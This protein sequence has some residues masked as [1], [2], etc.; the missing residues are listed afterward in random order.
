VVRALEVNQWRCASFENRCRTEAFCIRLA[1]RFTHLET[2]FYNTNISFSATA[3]KIPRIR[4]ARANTRPRLQNVGIEHRQ[5][6]VGYYVHFLQR[7]L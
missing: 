1:E 3:S 5:A 2:S 6:Q 4:A 7:L